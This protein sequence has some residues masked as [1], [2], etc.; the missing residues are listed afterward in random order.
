MSQLEAAIAATDRAEER[1]AVFSGSTPSE[2]RERIKRAFNGDPD[3]YPLR[4]LVATDAARKGLN[5]QSRCHNL[6]HFDVPWNPSKLEQCNGRIDRK[7]QPEPEV[8]CH[9]FYYHQRQED[10]I[11]DVIVRK[12]ETI[13]RELGSLSQVVESRPSEL[14][15]KRGIRRDGV[16]AL[17]REIDGE[18]KP[19]DC[20]RE[21]MEELEQPRESLD[22][23]RDQVKGLETR[24]EE[25]RRHTGFREEHFRDALDHALGLLD[26]SALTSV[27]SVSGEPVRYRFPTLDT[28]EGADITWVDT[29]D[30]LR[31]MCR[32]E[33][34]REWRRAAEVRPV[35]FADTGTMDEETVHLHL[36]HRVVQRLLGRFL[37]QG[38]IHHDLSRA[39]LAQTADNIPRV[40]LL[41]RLC[42]YGHNARPASRGDR[43][44]GRALDR[45]GEAHGGSQAIRH[46]QR[47]ED[48]QHA[49]R[50][51]ETRRRGRRTDGDPRRPS[52]PRLARYPRTSPGHPRRP[53]P[54]SSS[55]PTRH[56]DTKGRNRVPQ[57][58]GEQANRAGRRPVFTTH[59]VQSIGSNGWSLHATRVPRRNSRHP[60]LEH[61]SWEPSAFD[62]AF[63]GL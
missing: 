57:D 58:R 56:P 37:A 29:L 49:R 6:F 22:K 1:I 8:F 30:T 15:K 17:L 35:V 47:G 23:L 61:P 34:T 2:E 51:V 32:R 46:R 5:L 21:G 26:V 62:D 53:S 36:E 39:Y 48:A 60:Y 55:S 9:Y 50:G 44:R 19:G 27:R 54:P 43:A 20:E 59:S 10:Q 45:S 63:P 7:L 18:T 13:K 3:R 28:R 31:P 33:Q 38:F 42:L 11:L 25:F 4:I 14:L 16:E 12:T 52:V 40:I 41:G 24:I